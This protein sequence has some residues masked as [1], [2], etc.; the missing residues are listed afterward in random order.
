MP[1]PTEP[2][3]FLVT[4]LKNLTRKRRCWKPPV[5]VTLIWG[6]FYS[7]MVIARVFSLNILHKVES[8]GVGRWRGIPLRSYMLVSMKIRELT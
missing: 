6:W 5:L 8:V 3:I 4:A 7:L 2:S 1:L